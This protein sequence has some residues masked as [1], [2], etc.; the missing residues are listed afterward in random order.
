MLFISPLKLFSF[1]RYVEFSLGLETKGKINF[2]I[3]DVTA[4]LRN[5]YNTHIDQYLKK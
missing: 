1:S 5:I 4:W 3:D 2:E